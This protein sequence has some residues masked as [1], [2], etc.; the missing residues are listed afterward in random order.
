MT[1]FQDIFRSSFLENVS[2]IPM[3]DMV[4]ALL[5]VTV[6]A[7]DGETIYVGGAEL[8]GS[9]DVPSMP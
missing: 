4:L 7:A 3:F 6:S 1:T 8:L 5:L 9:A 2:T